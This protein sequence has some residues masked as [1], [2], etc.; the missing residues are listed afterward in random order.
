MKLG[1]FLNQLAGKVGQQ[2]NADLVSLLSNSELANAEIA[3]ALATA[4]NTGLMS[5]DGAKQSADVLKHFRPIILKGIDD[6]M[7][8]YATEAG[9]AEDYG[10]EE[11]S[12]KKLS[13]VIAKAKEA[14]ENAKKNGGGKNDAEIQ[15][16]TAKLQELQNQQ[17]TAIAA[18]DAEI[19]RLQD[20]FAAETISML[21][22][23]QLS[24]KQYA[25][26]SV[27]NDINV[28][29]ARLIVDDAIKAKKAIVVNDGGT[30]RLKQADAPELDLLDEGHKPVTFSD[31]CDQALAASGTLKTSQQ[32]TQHSTPAS[33]NVQQTQGEVRGFAEAMQASMNA[34]K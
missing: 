34:L 4:L 33:V 11:T 17:V 7:S 27:S 3:D 10:K 9:F 2:T 31:L 15:R 28:K 22:N 29:L 14:V 5:L 16:L 24:G 1:E 8:A 12:Y 30:L 32:Q 25:N 21:I 20:Q 19:K 18:K 6:Q 23:N 13:L 26:E